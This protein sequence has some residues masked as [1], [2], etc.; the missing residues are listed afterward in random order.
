MRALD[1][2]FVVSIFVSPSDSTEAIKTRAPLCGV[3]VRPAVPVSWLPSIGLI[4]IYLFRES[5]NSKGISVNVLVRR[6]AVD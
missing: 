1:K 5:V 4:I 3:S 6:H 2:K